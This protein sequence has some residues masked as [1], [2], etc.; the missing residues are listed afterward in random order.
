VDAL[1]DRREIRLA[2]VLNGGVSLAIWIGGV[3]AEID[4]A[5]R[6]TIPADETARDE[7][8]QIYKALLDL[9]CCALRTD[10]IAGASAGGLNGC[11]LATA[12]A[13][14]GTV[15]NVRK[16][17]IDLGSFRMMLRSGREP[18]PP[19]V[20]K[21]DDFFLPRL[22]EQFNDRSSPEAV[23]A[24]LRLPGKV[25]SELGP[26][27]R[28]RLL[29][30]GTDLG[31]EPHVY[32][33]SFGG[34]LHDREH[35]ALFVMEHDLERGRSSFDK[36]DA[37]RRLARIARSTASFPGAFEASFCRVELPASPPDEAAETKKRDPNLYAISTMSSS[38]WVADGGI[39]DNAPFRPALAAI[40][41]APSRG[42][43]RR[44]LCYV[45]PYGAPP[46]HDP[47][48]NRSAEPSVTGVV[49]A[50]FELPRSL[51]MTETLDEFTRYQRRV[52]SRRA[53]RLTL[54]AR[55]GPALDDH[56]LRVFDLY[57][58]QRALS[59]VDD[60]L[61][62]L[63][64]VPPYPAGAWSRSRTRPPVRAELLVDTGV[65]LPWVPDAGTPTLAPVESLLGKALVKDTRMD[66]EWP[67]G[68]APITRA[69][70]LV[71]DVL[72]RTLA[73]TPPPIR[74]GELDEARRN[75]YGARERLSHAL[76]WAGETAD[77]F[78]SVAARELAI[79]DDYTDAELVELNGGHALDF[80]G[81]EG[82]ARRQLTALLLACRAYRD[83]VPANECR[84]YMRAVV[85]ALG[86]GGP[87]AAVLLRESTLALEKREALALELSALLYGP[88]QDPRDELHESADHITLAD[89]RHARLLRLEIA[90]EALAPSRGEHDQRIDLLRINAEAPC[91]LDGRKLPEEKL[92]G[93]GLAHFAA[94]YKRSWRANDWMWGRLDGAR[95]LAD[96]LVDPELFRLRLDAAPAD[97]LQTETLAV[98]DSLLAIARPPGAV[99]T[100]L[101]TRF[102]Q[103]I[104]G[105]MDDVLLR[106]LHE[107]A[108][109]PLDETPP[110]PL[111]GC[112]Y[113]VAARLQLGIAAEELPVV[114][115]AAL[116]DVREG[117]SADAS[118][119][120][121]ARRN[122]VEEFTDPVKVKVA[123][124]DLT[125]A[126]SESFATEAGSNLLTRNVATTA[127]VAAS[128]ASARRSGIPGPARVVARSLRGLLLGVYGLAWSLT[129]P[130]PWVKVLGIGVLVGAAALVA[131]G[132]Y[133]DV[134][135]RTGGD[136]GSPPAWLALLARGIVA[137]A[138]VLGIL[139]A[140]WAGVVVALGFA[141]A[142]VSLVLWPWPEGARDGIERLWKTSPVATLLV[143]LFV[144]G[145]V[146]GLIVDARLRFRKPVLL[147]LSLA[148]LATVAIL[149]YVL[150]RF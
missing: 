73:I 23:R 65:K 62:R 130:R 131:W 147:L 126:R 37:P 68:L 57:C 25:R 60:V 59:S 148:A 106:E 55:L 40:E 117:A 50:A 22:V 136:A 66:A 92:T 75:I 116:E 80:K 18:Q 120:E 113:A 86:Q 48:A 79:R 32:R 53:G 118:G 99:G 29:V 2:L 20:L 108:R 15:A 61:D 98:R 135:V 89:Q 35:R 9:T 63:C 97:Q 109:W 70:R 81:I 78:L 21:G 12:I 69:A 122:P 138:L 111:N 26:S 102:E 17:W 133:S 132:L 74:P 96:L 87:E 129:S 6:A 84:K 24:R 16:T 143:A 34:D 95:R 110:P 77:K 56:A 33:D 43:V 11:L 3:V 107:L 100:Y 49:G 115:E 19:S 128:A 51:S 8:E 94:F 141:V 1:A 71:L 149:V 119:A 101:A 103:E 45:T 105:A 127:A 7:C 52:E 39:L 64:G 83:T 5:R 31:G 91:T 13:N 139:R 47:A 146:A 123:L 72:S 93:L 41:K 36:D 54:L 42:P 104:G 28:V 121:W 30:T 140:G 85:K 150:A 142:Y 134:D 58:R 144:L 38:R 27:E 14:H 124:S 67:W 46:E 137:A 10:V 4:R 90:Y 114:R 88:L 112:R 82:E 125:L 44:V 145:A 76:A